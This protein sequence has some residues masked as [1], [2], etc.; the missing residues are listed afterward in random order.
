MPLVDLTEDN[1]D[2]LTAQHEIL[3]LDFWASW[4]G[5]CQMFAPVFADAAARHP[6]ILFGK[7]NTETQERLA[8]QFEI[9]SVPTL[10]AAK[11]DEIVFA[12]PGALPPHKLES[13]IQDLKKQ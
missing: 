4:C 7:V 2:D 10:I 9:F 5:P 1:F 6:D 3:I 8:K 13:L 11:N 12:R